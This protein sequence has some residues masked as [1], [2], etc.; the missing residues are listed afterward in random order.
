MS[1]VLVIG[2]VLIILSLGGVV[3]LRQRRL[4]EDLKRAREEL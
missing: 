2:L 1:A 3:L 4:I